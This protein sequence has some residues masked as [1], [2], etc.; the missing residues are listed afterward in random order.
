MWKCSALSST[1]FSKEWHEKNGIN[2][3][4]GKEDE[5][6]VKGKLKIKGVPSFYESHCCT[7]D[8]LKS[9]A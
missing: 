6:R 8:K 9:I 7:L 5:N 3:R 4:M 2:K 1:V